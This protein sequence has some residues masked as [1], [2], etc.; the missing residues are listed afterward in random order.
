MTQL[1]YLALESVEQDTLQPIVIIVHLELLSL[2]VEK[3]LYLISLII[4]KHV[5]VLIWLLLILMELKKI[6]LF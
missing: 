4:L 2:H 1:F 5:L 3:I 6:R